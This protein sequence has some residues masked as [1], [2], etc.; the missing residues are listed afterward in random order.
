MPRRWN[1][2]ATSI[3]LI[4]PKSCPSGS[5]AAVPTTPSP[6][7]STPTRCPSSRNTRQSAL[8][9]FQPAAAESS[10]ARPRSAGPSTRDDQRSVGAIANVVVRGL[11][12]A[13]PTARDPFGGPV[14]HRR[15]RH[16]RPPEQPLRL[17]R[18]HQPGGRRLGAHERRLDPEPLAERLRQRADARRLRTAD[19][20][21]AGERGAIGER[22][23][24]LAVRITLPD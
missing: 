16:L 2:G 1:D 12:E 17:V 5:V 13:R 7:T 9:W 23:Q 24:R 6:I 18:I 20:Q 10:I 14:D 22:A 21:A 19:V 15:E 11:A 8:T 4:Q 3:M